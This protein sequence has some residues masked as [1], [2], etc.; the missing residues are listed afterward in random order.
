MAR[1][2]LCMFS[3]LLV[4]A[5]VAA[6]DD[7]GQSGA[8]EAA[9][10]EAG[11]AFVE[12][13][14]SHDAKAVA[15]FYAPEAVYTD[16]ATGDEVVGRDAIGKQFEKVFEENKDVKLD[17]A[18]DSIQ[19]LS[20]NVALEHGV[21]SFVAPEV[22]PEAIAYFAVYVRQDGKWLLDRVTDEAPTEEPPSHYEQLK[23]L[24]WMIGSWA[25]E[26]EQGRITTQCSWTRNRNFI[27][28]SFKV[29]IDEYL[30]LAGIQIIGWD[31]AEKRIRSWTFDSD[32]G[33]SE[34]DWI[35]KGDRWHVSHK[36][37]T[38][39]GERAAMVNVITKIDEDTMVLESI[40][41]SVGGEI[42]PSFDPVT[43]MRVGE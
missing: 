18:V 41:R 43:V 1:G 4:A 39:D 42:L 19:F 3:C 20:P 14:N 21:A 38:A 25:D 33:F 17:I 34:A 32:G 26:S 40:Q 8:D 37:V 7:G 15:G 23:P 13:Y 36:A 12:A 28:R 30:T 6:Q 31:A 9:I 29:E 35:N 27:T 11:L 24:E 22:E 2:I 5:A 16:R 10:R